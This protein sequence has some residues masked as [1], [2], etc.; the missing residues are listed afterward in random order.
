MEQ[1]SDSTE[2]TPTPSLKHEQDQKKPSIRSFIP[3][4][5]S[6]PPPPR[7]MRPPVVVDGGQ[8]EDTG[9][10]ERDDDRSAST[11]DQLEIDDI[12]LTEKT[13]EE[14]EREQ[15]ENSVTEKEV[16]ESTEH[17]SDKEEEEEEEESGVYSYVRSESRERLDEATPS[18]DLRPSSVQS[19][20]DYENVTEDMLNY[21]DGE[22]T[23]ETGTS[24][25]NVHR[26]QA[27]NS[28]D[29]QD[30]EKRQSRPTS[31][32]NMAPFPPDFKPPSPDQQDGDSSSDPKSALRKPKNRVPPP[33][34]P[35]YKEI[36]R[37]LSANPS[38]A[39]IPRPAAVTTR[40]QAM[41]S[42]SK[43]SLNKLASTPAN[44]STSPAAPAKPPRV[45][46]GRRTTPTDDAE[47]TLMLTGKT[48]VESSLPLSSRLSPRPSTPDS[49]PRSPHRQLVK[50][51][52]SN[53]LSDRSSTPESSHRHT[54]D[55]SKQAPLRPAPTAPGH[56][57]PKISRQQPVK[58][59]P[60]ARVTKVASKD[61][62]SPSAVRNRSPV[63]SPAS[64]QRA[65]ARSAPPPPQAL[66][67][68][69]A[70][71]SPSP[72][73]KNRSLDKT[74]KEGTHDDR[75]SPLPPNPISSTK[76][77]AEEESVREDAPI[78]SEKAAHALEAMKVKSQG[79]QTRLQSGQVLPI[80]GKV[81]GI[82]TFRHT[83]LYI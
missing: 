21:A 29:M 74:D 20:P 42:S 41:D 73:R 15:D 4:P 69:T 45:R 57:S 25:M 13:E 19:A 67:K 62:H 7:P 23:E 82:Y 5:P 77:S 49:I 28:E 26:S 51:Q 10:H 79:I 80:G 64:R 70:S 2:I 53:I 76:Q 65:P 11:R 43:P 61:Q 72:V 14:K 12:T 48:A 22:E 3:P 81:S 31:Y 83:A 16:E 36:L 54:A 75:G 60:P 66:E 71:P 56:A 44:I 52:S 18:P 38:S 68:K 55:Q 50:S 35:N 32:L 63:A 78:V 9:Q 30:D 59:P 47:A 17:C 46:A 1:E 27:M 34:P 24:Y 37:E 8:E 6:H 33:P 58:K 39:V 40:T